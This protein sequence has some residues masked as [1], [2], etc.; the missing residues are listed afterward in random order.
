M[1]D[2]QR[3]SGGSL[4]VFTPVQTER[5]RPPIPLGYGQRE[6]LREF[7]GQL[8]WPPSPLRGLSFGFQVSR[9]GSKLPFVYKVLHLSSTVVDGQPRSFPQKQSSIAMGSPGTIQF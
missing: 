4:T 5:Q 1:I 8:S 9:S 3:Q 2:D 7:V 6:P